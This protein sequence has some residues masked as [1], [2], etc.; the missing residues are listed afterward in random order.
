MICMIC[1]RPECPIERRLAALEAYR[2]EHP[3]HWQGE[4]TI[5]ETCGFCAQNK[6]WT[7]DHTGETRTIDFP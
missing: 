6:T 5:T 3:A 4:H 7:R 1:A 2:A